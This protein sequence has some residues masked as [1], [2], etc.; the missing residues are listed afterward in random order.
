MYLIVGLGNPGKEYADTRHNA[1]FMVVDAFAKKYRIEFEREECRALVGL[2]T[3]LGEKVVLAKPLTYMNLSGESVRG[4]MRQYE[5][6]LKHLIVVY[7]DVDLPMGRLRIREKGS[8]GGQNGMKNIIE[9]VKS[10]EFIRLRVGTG[11]RPGGSE[12]IRFVLE[13]LK[14]EDY[15]YLSETI[16]NCGAEALLRMLRK[17]GGIQ[18]AGRF[19]NGLVI[20]REKKEETE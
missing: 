15:I 2:G 18:D 16:A 14:D 20:E 7:D 5:V 1:G 11:P 3:V 13:H 10:E 6:D 8:A 9:L 4:L 17:N 19:A 12:M